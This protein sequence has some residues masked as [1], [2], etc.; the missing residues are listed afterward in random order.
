MGEKEMIYINTHDQKPRWGWASKLERKGKV[1]VGT[2]STSE[3][4]QD[5][6]Y[7]KSFWNAMF[8]GGE[9]HEGKITITKAKIYKKDKYTNLTVYEWEQE[10]KPEDESQIQPQIPEG[11]QALEDDDSI[12]F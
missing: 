5:G 9:V 2:V 3:K 1:I 6:N 8:V 10:Y 11:F 4:D 7:I 12:P